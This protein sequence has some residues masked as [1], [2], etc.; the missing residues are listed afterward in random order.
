MT[1]Q[2]AAVFITKLTNYQSKDKAD[3]LQL[4]KEAL[5]FAHT[6]E[7]TEIA[8]RLVSIGSPYWFTEP[9][10]KPIMDDLAD[11]EVPDEAI[12][13][14]VDGTELDF[15]EEEYKAYMIFAKAYVDYRWRKL[16]EL[17]Q[18]K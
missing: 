12:V 8:E 18:T 7:R 3:F 10:I 2:Q 4:C 6:S 16:A 9:D 11:I 1:N 14:L 5:A 17:L 15:N 13:P